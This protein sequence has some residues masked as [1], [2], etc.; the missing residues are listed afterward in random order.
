MRLRLL[1]LLAGL[2]VLSI[3]LLIPPAY[4]RGNGAANA[5]ARIHYSSNFEG[6]LEPCG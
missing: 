3:A 6:E 1:P 2:L 4:A 5:R